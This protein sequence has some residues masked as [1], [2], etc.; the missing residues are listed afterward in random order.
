MSILASLTMRR[1]AVVLC[2]LAS[3]VHGRRMQRTRESISD[4]R[5]RLATLLLVPNN[6]SAGWHG[7]VFAAMHAN[8]IAK[9]HAAMLR[10]PARSSE[11]GMQLNVAYPTDVVLGEGDGV[12]LERLSP[13]RDGKIVLQAGK[14]MRLTAHNVELVL[15][16]LRPH[17][18]SDG[19]N[20][21]LVEI[22]G[23]DVVLELNGACVG[24]ASA[25]TTMQMGLARRLK[26][27]IPEISEVKQRLPRAELTVEEVDAVLD[28]IRPFISMADADSKLEVVGISGPDMDVILTLQL[29]SA[30][31]E[32]QSI[33]PEIESMIQKESSVGISNP[34][35]KIIWQ[36]NA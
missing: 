16:E 35:M 28:Q 1:S 30:K 32:V 5:S 12:Q 36:D 31:E 21:K 24:C 23:H 22:E 2:L 19:G 20:V 9:P 14:T 15:D 29:L 13:F 10:I 7:P 27:A 34:G 25:A 4:R 3:A 11:V 17:L 8:S 18:V 26:Q 6:M 33:R